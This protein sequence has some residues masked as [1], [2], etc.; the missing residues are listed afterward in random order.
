VLGQELAAA[1]GVTDSGTFALGETAEDP[2]Q[3]PAPAPQPPIFPGGAYEFT[4]TASPGQRLS[5]ATMFIQSN[6]LLYAP[7]QDGVAL[8]ESDGTPVSGDITGAVNLYDAGT[9]VNEEPGVGPNQAPRQSGFDT[10]SDE[11]GVVR[12]IGQVD[13]GFSYPDDED[14]IEVTVTPQ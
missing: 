3:P 1:S 11:N 10:G 13:D 9:E 8:F 2:N 14:V 4:V 6:D 5:F 7:G 12:P